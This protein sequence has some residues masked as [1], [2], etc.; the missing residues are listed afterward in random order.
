LKPAEAIFATVLAAGPAA[1]QQQPLSAIEWLND[2]V[3]LAAPRLPLGQEPPVAP[4]VM[5]PDVSVMPLGESRPDGVG[6]LPAGV[7]GLPAT[8]WAASSETTLIDLWSGISHEPLPAVQALYYTLLLSEADAPEGDDGRFLRVR[9]ERLAMLGA[10][11][12]A[13]ALLERAGPAEPA[14]FAPWFDLTLLS[15]GEGRACNALRRQPE[16]SPGHAARIYCAARAGDWNTA[17]V[18]FE[19]SRALGLLSAPVARLLDQFLHPGLAEGGVPLAPPRSPSPLEFRLHEAVGASLPTHSLPRAFAVADLR[20]VAGWKAKLEAAERLART[21]AVSPNRL[22][23]LYTERSPA[24]SGGVWDRVAAIQALDSALGNADPTRIAQA[25][26]AAWDAMQ[27]VRLEVPFAQLFSARLE[28]FDLPSD[29]AGLAW[30]IGLLSDGYETVAMRPGSGREARFLAGV[31]H[32]EPPLELAENTLERAVG[33][34][35][36]TTRA[37]PADRA[38]LEQGRLGEAILRAANRLDAAGRGDGAAIVS[39]LTTLRAVGLED[40]ARRSAL[41]LL[42]LDRRR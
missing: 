14:L 42:L 21:G 29:S 38:L 28:D 34:A 5:V 20:S 37:A 40:S 22:L 19:V 7:T 18:I 16:L 1:A 26:P 15:G 10:V 4:T 17:T 36:A 24:A 13:I 23:G 27:S 31:A 9:V 3:P 11:E 2:P 25:L 33:D 39:G 12:P 35:F 6:L 30:E 8:L 32:G 41:Q